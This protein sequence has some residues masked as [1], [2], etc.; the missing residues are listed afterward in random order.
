LLRALRDARVQPHD[1][2]HVFTDATGRPLSQEWLHKRVWLP[3]LH[4]PARPRAVQHPRHLH[5]DRAVAR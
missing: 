5:L 4:G 1:D 3:T 2:E